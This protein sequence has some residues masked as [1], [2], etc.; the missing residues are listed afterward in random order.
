MNLNLH[1]NVN[2]ANKITAKKSGLIWLWIA[3]FV[4]VLDLTSKFYV[5]HNFMLGESVPVMPFLNFAYAQN[6]G[7]AFGFL[8]EHS[9][10]QRWFFT[11]IAVSISSILVYFMR[12]TPSNHK[13]INIGY[14][15]VIGGAL[16]NLFDR[17]VHG[18]VID[19]IDFYIGNWHF[20]TFNIADIAICVGAGLILLDGLF[21]HKPSQNKNNEANNAN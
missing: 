6:T 16:G 17:L 2:D 12:K 1:Q 10:W 5:L 20:A 13:M 18:F 4:I 15:M 3:I 19:F 11:L 8:S 21:V 9:G 14:A 7:A